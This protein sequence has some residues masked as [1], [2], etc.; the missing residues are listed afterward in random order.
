MSDSKQQ[1]SPPPA[2]LHGSES[3]RKRKPNEARTFSRLML[4]LMACAIIFTSI[5][6]DHLNNTNFLEEKR[7]YVHNK[8]SVIK[9]QLESSVNADIQV[10]N[11]VRALIISDPDI[12]QYQ[13]SA[14]ATPLLQD[15]PHIRNVGAAPNMVIRMVHPLQGNESAL[16]LDF[17]AH[18]QQRAGAELARDSGNLVLSEPVN[19]V[20][21]GQAFIARL[22]VFVSSK[23]DAPP[24]FWGL[25]STLIDSEKLYKI[26]GLYD[27]SAEFNL[28]IRSRDAVSSHS[29]FFGSAEL[30]N[31]DPVVLEATLPNATWQIAAIPIEGWP[32]RASNAWQVRLMIGLAGLMIFVPM[33]FLLRQS[34]LRQDNDY[35]L[36]NLFEL[37]PVGIALSDLDSGEFL[38][39]NHS[40]VAPTGYTPEAFTRLNRRELTPEIYA[41]EEAAQLNI[42]KA[43]G[44]YGPYEKEFIKKDGS[45]Y[46]VVLN[47]ILFTNSSGQRLIWSIVEDISA[48][49]K[50]EASLSESAEQLELVINSTGVGFWDW[51]VQSGALTVNARWAEMIGYSLDEIEP[52]SIKTWTSYAH[53]EDLP[54]STKKL[55]DHWQGLTDAY[56][57]ETRMR[58]KSGHWIWVLATG[59]VV[60]WDANHKPL[61][62]VGTHIDI[63]EQKLAENTIRQAHEELASQVALIQAIAKAQSDFITNTSEPRPAFEALLENLLSLTGSKYGFIGE[64]L[65]KPNGASYLKTY[66][67]TNIA[68]NDETTAFYAKNSPMGM[69]FSNMD[70]LF[71][72]AIT[73]LE[74]VI[75]NAPTTDRRRGG[76]P[77]GLPPLNAFLGIPIKHRGVPIALIGLANRPSGYDQTM[78]DWLMPL[79]STIGQLIEGI[80]I[81]AARSA[82]ESALLLAKEDAETAARAKSEFL[83]IM[84]H[85]IRTPMNSILGMLNLL[86]RSPLDNGQKRKLSVAKNSADALLT[87]I[88]DILD[89]SKIDAGK[90]ELEH[91]DFDLQEMLGSFAES[92]A[93]RAQDAGLELVLDIVDIR[94]SMVRSDP[95]RLRQIL[96]NLVGN[97]IKFTH[98]GH[99]VLR[100][101]L[102]TENEKMCFTGSITDTGIG[103]PKDKLNGLFD[104]FTQVDASTT[105]HYGGTGLGLAICKRLCELMGGSLSAQSTPDQG[106]CFT[107]T[108]TMQP[109]PFASTIEPA[110][111][112]S[113]LHILLVDDNE[114]N[115]N[116]LHR[117]LQDWGVDVTCTDGAND[118][119][120][121]L[122]SSDSHTYPYQLVLIDLNMEETD[123]AALGKQIK[124]DSRFETIPLVMMTNMSQR[125]DTD[126]FKSIGFNGY[127]SKPATP[128]DLLMALAIAL[129]EE[130]SK[131]TQ[132]IDDQLMP[133]EPASADANSLS[134]ATSDWPTDTRLLLVED[135]AFNQEVAKLLLEEMGLSCDVAGNG[136]EA[137]AALKAASEIT[138]YSLVLMDC[139]MPEMDGY[140]ASL[141]IRAGRAGDANKEVAIIAM[142]AN[143]MQGD[144]AKCLD[145]GMSD[146]LS[147][148]VDAEKMKAMLRKWLIACPLS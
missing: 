136:I 57:V 87:L 115:R 145:A 146:Y 143:A 102:S 123:G 134:A 106:S 29:P 132:A 55:N 116:V 45:R 48:R 80:R 36:R 126:Y 12:N 24:H 144:E 129:P 70:S 118:A 60:E 37:S 5:Y 11:S 92:V 113:K 139:Q 91:L 6:I 7:N 107:F 28:A 4:P 142:T 41:E 95:G 69:E 63:T 100:C 74:P 65:K 1:P 96:N 26:S 39:V 90:L 148:P 15:L 8:V 103:I 137:L 22:P 62:M 97:A 13:F 98:Q 104:A 25:V 112:L 135:N 53:P 81:E 2:A 51:Q 121:A 114:T 108:I 72:A 68:W 49:K 105:R 93:L 9:S 32:T 16:G 110:A 67:I 73:S 88:N 18:E 52:I 61:R 94:T 23:Q 27:H 38:R 71:G 127:F 64:I 66:A 79:M 20:Q 117:Q 141:Q 111:A 10:V 122:E 76:A 17:M 33:I 47:G 58:H 125:G 21:G 19:L 78:V 3:P 86:N 131:S 85:E 120:K 54:A 46:P 30:F 43:Q 50:S 82:T 130:N 31:R 124:T 109:S 138:P 99:I 147:K 128:H 35:L 56:S 119:W 42:L 59:K 75:A 84:S 14:F 40:L 83:A 140:E 77:E 133:D 89:F 44:R 34:R 101:S